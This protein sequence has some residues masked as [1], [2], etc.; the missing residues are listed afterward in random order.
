MWRKRATG[1]TGSVILNESKASSSHAHVAADAPTTAEA[2]A[3]DP[4]AISRARGSDFRSILKRRIRHRFNM[5]TA[6]RLSS[7]TKTEREREETRDATRLEPVRPQID[8]N[9]STPDR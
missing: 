2:Q 7:Q 9:D 6:L 5:T 4:R 8:T 1:L 3:A